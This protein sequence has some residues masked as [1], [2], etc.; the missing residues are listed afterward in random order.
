[1]DANCDDMFSLPMGIGEEQ[2]QWPPHTNAI[3]Y[4]LRSLKGEVIHEAP[5]LA[6]TTRARKGKA[7]MGLEVEGQ[8]EYSS[9][10][11]LNILEL[12]KVARV[13]RNVTKEI[14]KENTILHDRQKPNVE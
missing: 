6:V 13:A 14:K 11:G 5:A 7:L 3:T 4:E 9:D 8:E 10:E 1:M 2:S 12:D